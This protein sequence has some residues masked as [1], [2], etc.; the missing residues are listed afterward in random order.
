MAPQEISKPANVLFQL[1][2]KTFSFSYGT[3]TLGAFVLLAYVRKNNFRKLD[4][5][6]KKELALGKII[7]LEM[8]LILHVE[9]SLLKRPSVLTVPDSHG[10]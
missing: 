7:T 10:V 5:E 3:F 6:G 8:S 2:W 4:A 9:F 1:A